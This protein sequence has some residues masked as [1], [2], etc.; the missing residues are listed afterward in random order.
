MQRLCG[1][2]GERECVCFCLCV[3]EGVSE[4]VRACVF[5]FVYVYVFLCVYVCLCAHVFMLAC[6][7][8]C[9]CTCASKCLC[10]YVCVCI[11]TLFVGFMLGGLLL[12]HFCCKSKQ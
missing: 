8:V 6:V 9:A 7:C 2:L 1:G 11:T 3:Y 4:L 10:M 12:L 5:S